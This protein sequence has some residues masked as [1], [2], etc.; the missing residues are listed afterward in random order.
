MK[1]SAFRKKDVFGTKTSR[2]IFSITV[3]TRK[4]YVGMCK[5]RITA[6]FLYCTKGQLISKCIFDVI[7]FLQKT[8]ENKSTWGFICSSKVKFVRSFFGG[9][10]GL[11]N[12]FRLFL[13]FNVVRRKSFYHLCSG[14]STMSK[15]KGYSPYANFITANFITGIFQ[16]FPDIFG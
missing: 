15:Y 6:F 4:K 5:L 12:S 2:N 7:N 8:N 3:I 11:K 13:T 14:L 10:V 1:L 16:K 9:N